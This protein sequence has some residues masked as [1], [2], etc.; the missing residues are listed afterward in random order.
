MHHIQTHTHINI[1]QDITYTTINKSKVNRSA[2][3]ICNNK[4]TLNTINREWNVHGEPSLL[5]SNSI[6]ALFLYFRFKS[7]FYFFKSLIL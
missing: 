3:Y 6:K 2:L 7:A 4:L 1:K 5:D